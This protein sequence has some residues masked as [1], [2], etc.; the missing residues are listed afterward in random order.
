ML[1][2]IGI[3]LTF[4]ALIFLWS[5]NPIYAF[6][7]GI[8]IIVCIVVA[9]GMVVNTRS[10]ASPASRTPEP[11]LAHRRTGEF[12]AVEEIEKPE[13]D[14][15]SAPVPAPTQAR[16]EVPVPASPAPAPQAPSAPPKLAEPET[17]TPGVDAPIADKAI[18][19][20]E[21]DWD[22]GEAGE[23]DY[24][25]W[26]D[27]EE[28]AE[29]ISL[30]APPEPDG[31]VGLG[32][33][34]GNRNARERKKEAEEEPS[35][36]LAGTVSNVN[37][38]ELLFS[39][40]GEQRKEF[41]ERVGG[42]SAAEQT[43]ERVLAIY[44]EV[45]GVSLA[46]M[47]ETSSTGKDLNKRMQELSRD[48]MLI[49]TPEP[50]TPEATEYEK[51][52]QELET[53]YNQ[54]IE[55]TVAETQFTAY[56][57][58]QVAA[59]T[60]YGF[61]VYAHLPDALISA[62]VE[63]F[64]VELGG[65]VPKPKVAQETAKVTE[66]AMLTVM[67]QCEALKFNQ[68]GAM[69][70]WRT[71]FVRFDFAFTAEDE[72]LIDE[73]VEGQVAIL[74]GMIEIA[75]IDFKILVTEPNPIASLTAKPMNPRN[76]PTFEASEPTRVYQQIFVSYSRKDSIVAESYRRAQ[77]MAG[78]TV[79]MDTHSIRAGEDWEAALKRFID[80]ADV[81]QLFWSEHA[82]QSEHV[83][84][85]WDYALKHR[86]PDTR[87]VKFIRPAYWQKPLPNVPEEL[88]HLHF[89]FVEFF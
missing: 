89:A 65:H 78:N 20:D 18:D 19:D 11:V 39:L 47:E 32:A 60:E 73:V 84:F 9:V 83:R 80:D 14:W 23:G 59:K 86:C 43:D 10:S 50:N 74:L 2:T 29:D 37:S 1:S 41:M 55:T 17:S 49:P 36:T 22:E 85:E 5:L 25:V 53:L 30:S 52:R 51:K 35:S 57:P 34:E 28:N 71:P 48:L 3:I 88:S 24:S 15:D 63:Q 61:Y 40:E 16:P 8:V 68:V 75:S 21:L 62:D 13:H 81:F 46:E 45:T 87:C 31:S 4:T 82:A 76:A 69:Q 72:A 7:S 12:R 6:I 77:M 66:G 67:M 56:F 70:Q 44:R 27:D 26:L 38:V 58:R 33:A 64:E 79:F 42:L 54:H